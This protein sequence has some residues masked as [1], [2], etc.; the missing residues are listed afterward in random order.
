MV[1]PK[2]AAQVEKAKPQEGERP[3]RNDPQRGERP[4]RP[5]AQLLFRRKGGTAATAQATTLASWAIQ[6]STRKAAATTE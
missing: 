6:C 1:L 2:S 3:E 5:H 4:R